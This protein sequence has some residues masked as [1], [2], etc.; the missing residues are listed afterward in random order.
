MLRTSLRRNEALSKESY[1]HKKPHPRAP[2]FHF[3]IR[4]IRDPSLTKNL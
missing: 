4:K 2:F 3:H 1:G